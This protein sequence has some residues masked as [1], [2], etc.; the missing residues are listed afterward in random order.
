MEFLPLLAVVV[1]FWLLIVR[2]ASRRQ[3]QLQQL[4]AGLATG[5]RIVLASGLY[6][7]VDGLDVEKVRVEIAPGVVVD[8]AR[9]AVAAVESGPADATGDVPTHEEG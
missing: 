7:T 2:P 8:V 3:K 5:D 6:G 9:G 1:V 4:Q